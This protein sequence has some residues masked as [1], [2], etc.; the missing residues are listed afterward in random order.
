MEGR[1]VQKLIHY[2]IPTHLQ[3]AFTGKASDCVNAISFADR[4]VSLPIYPELTDEEV[5]HVAESCVLSLGA[6][7]KCGSV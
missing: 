5:R 1:G 7:G 4:V 6:E 3:K 2:P